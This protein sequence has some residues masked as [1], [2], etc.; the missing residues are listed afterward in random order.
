MSSEKEKDTLFEHAEKVT[1]FVFDKEVADV[2][3]DMLKRSVPFYTET[4]LMA[5]SLAKNFVRSNT[6]IYDLGCSTGNV[7]KELVKMIPDETVRFVGVDNADSMLNKTRKKLTGYDPL[8]RVELI[9]KDISDE[10][11]IKNA[12]VVIMN[13]TLQF[14]RPLQREPLIRQIYNGL[15]DNGCLI[16]ME[17]VLGNDSLFNRLYIQLYYEFKKKQGYSEKEIAQKREA[18]ENVLIPYRID[19]NIDLLK[20]CGFSSIDLFYKW[21]NF[22]GFI[23]VR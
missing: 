8:K 22:A 2:F 14:V 10:I 9:N 23:A 13:Y 21:Y 5:L 4:Q 6:A 1:D 20:K 19:E 16:L 17:K 3:D 18:L 7:L 11:G 12:S 15:C